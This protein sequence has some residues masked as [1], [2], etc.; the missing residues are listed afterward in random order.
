MGVDRSSIP[1]VVDRA[2]AVDVDAA[3]FAVHFLGDTA[4]FVLGEEAIV[5]A[6]RDGHTERV[7][8]HGGAILSSASD[9]ARVVTGGDDGKMAAT[10]AAGKTETLAAD[11]K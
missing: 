3:V 2:R 11:A 10:D 1:S 7:T 8:V 6:A 5:L 9:D 4:A